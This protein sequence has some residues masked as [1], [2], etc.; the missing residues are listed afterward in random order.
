MKAHTS[1]PLRRKSGPRGVSYSV[2]VTTVLALG[3]CRHVPSAPID[4]AANAA[5]LSAQSLSDPAVA[6]ALAQ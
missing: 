1:S 6:D 2:L 5:R 3:A 4:P